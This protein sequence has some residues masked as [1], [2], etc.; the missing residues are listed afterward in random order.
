M[1]Q[2]DMCNPQISETS[3]T[4]SARPHGWIKTEC[5]EL[6]TNPSTRVYKPKKALAKGNWTFTL[7]ISTSK[8]LGPRDEVDEYVQSVR[9]SIIAEQGRPSSI[10]KEIGH[11]DFDIVQIR[12]IRKAGLS[13]SWVISLPASPA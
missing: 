7:D 4:S 5:A 11:M 8:S 10:V 12:R 6:P 2:Q 3:P 13:L 1:P 9:G